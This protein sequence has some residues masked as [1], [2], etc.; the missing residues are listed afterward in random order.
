MVK[1]TEYE[2]N[3]GAF[4]IPVGTANVGGCVCYAI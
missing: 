1:F 4:T 3:V 2:G